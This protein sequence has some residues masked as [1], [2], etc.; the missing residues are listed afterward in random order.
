MLFPK[1]NAWETFLNG[2]YSFTDDFFENGRSHGDVQAPSEK[3][4]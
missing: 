4:Q 2:L 1:E 3:Q